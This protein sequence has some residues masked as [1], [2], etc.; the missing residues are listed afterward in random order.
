[1][2]LALD[3]SAC[4]ETPADSVGESI[5]VLFSLSVLLVLFW[6]LK[7]VENQGRL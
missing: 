5:S 1:M 6:C 3:L 2:P 4:S 7:T